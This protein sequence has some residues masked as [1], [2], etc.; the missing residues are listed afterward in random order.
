MLEI[1]D[2]PIIFSCFSFNFGKQFRVLKSQSGYE[3]RKVEEKAGIKAPHGAA[4]PVSGTQICHYL[5]IHVFFHKKVFSPSTE[6]SKL[7]HNSSIKTFLA[8]IFTT[9]S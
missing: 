3:G 8:E 4:L 2:T 7:F 9:P 5:G 6:L 1:C